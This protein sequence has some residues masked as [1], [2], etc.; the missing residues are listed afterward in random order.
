MKVAVGFSG[1]VDSTMAALL[2]KQQGHD[3]VGITMSLWDP[4]FPIPLNG[5][6]GCFG[7]EESTTLAQTQKTAEKLGIPHLIVPLA[8]QYRKSVID[9]F[10]DEYKAGRTPNPCVK[11]N[12]LMKFGFL[13]SCAKEMGIDFDAFATGHY[14][15]L[16][17]DKLTLKTALDETKD[18]TYFLSRLKKEQLK[19]VLFPLGDWKKEKVKELALNNGFEELYYKSESQDFIQCGDYSLLFNP[20]DIRP[21]SFVDKNGKVLGK[22][23]GIIYYTIGQRK[24]LGIGG[25]KEPLYVTRLDSQ[26]N[27]VIL[28]PHQDLFSNHLRGSDFN[29]IALDE[30]ISEGKATVK[31]RH[32]HKAVPATFYIEPHEKLHV[33]FDAPQLSVTPGQIVTLYDNESVLGS[34]IIDSGYQE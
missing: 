6:K 11:C 23:N 8:K 31:I 30:S 16:S 34:A 21:G 32:G 20:E 26:K 22:H 15:R 25:L 27:E 18:Q 28:G 19:N 5:N 29:R 1:G 33:V 24:G 10:R 12:Q 2:L 9:Y 3:V 14:A 13:L 4:S 17:E 7:P